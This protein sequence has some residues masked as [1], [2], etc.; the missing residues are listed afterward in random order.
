[1]CLAVVALDAHARYPLVVVANR[2]EFHARPAVAAHWWRSDLEHELLAGRDLEAGGT[3]LAIDRSGRWGFVTNVREPGR[4]D[5]AAPSRGQLVPRV[6]ADARDAASALAAVLA[7]S[8]RFNG[9]NLL[10]GDLARG[11]WAS[12]RVT[13]AR[14]LTP[15]VHGVSHAALDTPWPKLVRTRDAVAAWAAAGGAD[16]AALFALLADR[17]PAAD[18]ELPATGVPLEWE[19]RLSP[20]FIVSETY[21]TR[22]S[23][24]LTVARDGRARLVERSF[25]ARGDRTGEVEHC[26]D[27]AARS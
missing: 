7:D 18:D 8:A 6:L 2:D 24:V 5:A 27:V 1:M 9:F 13:G 19:R 23:T 20:P 15:G 11:A 12:N 22:C 16:C 14:V 4:R 17:T 3:W 26:F 10:A 21:G 25:D